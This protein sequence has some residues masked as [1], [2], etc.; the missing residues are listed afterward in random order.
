MKHNTHM[1]HVYYIYLHLVMYGENVGKYSSTME[2]MGYDNLSSPWLRFGSGSLWQD[3][4]AL[5]SES[6]RYFG[7]QGLEYGSHRKVLQHVLQFSESLILHGQR[8]S[9]KKSKQIQS[10]KSKK[11]S[12]IFPWIFPLDPRY[13][14]DSLEAFL[15]NSWDSVPRTSQWMGQYKGGFSWLKSMKN[16]GT[17]ARNVGLSGA[18]YV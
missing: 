6:C 16:P 10:Q 9:R 13:F 2:H 12:V 3:H 11:K 7:S 18:I 17:S 15:A 5:A 1:L 14:L 4:P 8:I